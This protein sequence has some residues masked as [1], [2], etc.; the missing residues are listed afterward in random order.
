[1]KYH[2]LWNSTYASRKKER[3]HRGI[4]ELFF[5]VVFDKMKM[6]WMY[7]ENKLKKWKRTSGHIVNLDLN[8]STPFE[9]P[10][11]S[12]LLPPKINTDRR[13]KETP[14]RQTW[15]KHWSI[16]CF[17][18]KWNEAKCERRWKKWNTKLNQ[19][20]YNQRTVRP[21]KQREEIKSI[22]IRGCFFSNPVASHL[23][24]LINSTSAALW[25]SSNVKLLNFESQH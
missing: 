5:T 7:Y 23:M 6:P 16:Y 3:I 15:D 9:L 8:T 14:G 4:I 20:L 11:R 18:A 22:S 19:R 24:I 25:I 10:S 2:W 17:I 12:L 13:E 1:M 21:L